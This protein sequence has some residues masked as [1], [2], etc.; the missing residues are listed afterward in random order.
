L[1]IALGIAAALALPA[2]AALKAEQ[3]PRSKVRVRC[4]TLSD[5]HGSKVLGRGAGAAMT[6]GDTQRC[7]PKKPEP[8]AVKP[9]NHE[10]YSAARSQAR[11]PAPHAHAAPPKAVRPERPAP[12]RPPVERV[13]IAREW[14]QDEQQRLDRFAPSQVERVS[15]AIVSGGVLW[16]LQSSFWASL[17]LLGLPL[18]RHVDL[19]A[20]VAR[21]PLDAAEDA[22]PPT[23]EDE[24]VARLLDDDQG[25]HSN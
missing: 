23:P 14:D 17:L 8:V 16:V 7:V 2:A 9:P 20:I 25:R 12:V 3:G 13:Q 15:T 11:V 10:S 21:A 4:G 18:W 6:D 22:V 24:R 5:H 19:L 1:T